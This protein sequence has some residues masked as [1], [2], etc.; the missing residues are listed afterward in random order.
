MIKGGRKGKYIERV[1]DR[2]RMVIEHCMQLIAMYCHFT[3]HYLL[4]FFL[5]HGTFPG[6]TQLVSV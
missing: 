3:F 2:G 5:L 4:L 1:M 6:Q